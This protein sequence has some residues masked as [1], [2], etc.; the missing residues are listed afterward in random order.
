MEA[1]IAPEIGGALLSLHHRGRLLTRKTPDDVLN[2]GNV[3]LTAGFPLVPYGNRI[4]EGHFNFAGRRVCL[5]ANFP[6]SSHPL[7]GFGWQRAWSVMQG[8]SADCVLAYE[9]NAGDEADWPFRFSA[10]LRYGL[11]PDGLDIS[12]YLTN[13]EDA[14]APAG[15]G[16][17][18]FFRVNDQ[19]RVHFKAKTLWSNDAQMLPQKQQPEE[20]RQFADGWHPAGGHFDNDIEGW[21]GRLVMTAMPGDVTLSMVVAP[22]FSWLRIFNPAKGDSFAAEPM[23]HATNAINRNDVPPMTVLSPGERMGGTISI[24]IA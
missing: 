14:A 7:H 2:T 6:G 23:T 10:E 12:L 17:H 13:R 18:P 4:A 8:S 20:I 22:V 19:T 3:R 11:R 24:S 5:A 9:A 1:Q 15:L 16:F 21:D